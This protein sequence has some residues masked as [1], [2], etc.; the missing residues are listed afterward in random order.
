ME[1]REWIGIEASVPLMADIRVTEFM[2]H[3]VTTISA[4]TRLAEAAHCMVTGRISGLPVVDRQD[5]LLGL[6]TEADFLRAVGVP[7]HHPACSVWQTLKS[8]F[9]HTSDMQQAD[10]LVSDLMVNQVITVRPEQTLRDVF[11]VM[12]KNRIKRV[13]VCDAQRRV[14]GIV[15]RSDMIKVFFDKVFKR[16]HIQG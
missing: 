5:R 10:D 8:I 1:M 12:K 15:T 4:D 14:R 11:E 3:P 16:G 13:V 6:V 9:S 2:S 7:C